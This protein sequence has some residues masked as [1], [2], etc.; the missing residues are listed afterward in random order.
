[1]FRHMITP[2]PAKKAS[3]LQRCSFLQFVDSFRWTTRIKNHRRDVWQHYCPDE[4]GLQPIDSILHL[5]TKQKRSTSIQA[6]LCQ[7]TLYLQ[8]VNVSY[9]RRASCFCKREH[10]HYHYTEQLQSEL[11]HAHNR[12]PN[13][14][15][16]S[17]VMI[18]IDEIINEIIRFLDNFYNQL[19]IEYCRNTIR[20]RVF[21]A[22]RLGRKAVRG[23]GSSTARSSKHAPSESLIV[24]V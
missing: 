17:E 1:M 14:S 3:L 10:H 5:V 18:Q 19:T 16:T 12:R 24:G 4:P 22:I 20:V 7:R 6:V 15:I 13:G 21:V 9:H 2:S 8:Q 11:Q 23:G